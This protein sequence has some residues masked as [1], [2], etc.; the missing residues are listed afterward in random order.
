MFFTNYKNTSKT[1]NYNR[2]VKNGLKLMQVFKNS[3][4]CSIKNNSVWK[5]IK[6]GTQAMGM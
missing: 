4:H 1:E 5:F 6:G 3:G 2:P